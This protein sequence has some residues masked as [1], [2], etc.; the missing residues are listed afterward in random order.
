MSSFQKVLNRMIFPSV[1]ISPEVINASSCTC[2]AVFFKSCD[3]RKECGF[4][5]DGF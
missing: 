3:E 2:A 4:V 1:F 5:N